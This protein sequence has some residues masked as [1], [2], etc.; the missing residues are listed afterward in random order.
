M[1]RNDLVAKLPQSSNGKTRDDLAKLFGVSARYIQDALAIKALPEALRE[2]EQRSPKDG[3]SSA[4]LIFN[5][6]PNMVKGFLTVQ[7]HIDRG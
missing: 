2:L 1:P 4:T 5:P 6:G 7:H 3:S